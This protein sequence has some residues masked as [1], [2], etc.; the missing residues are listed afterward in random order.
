VPK[1]PETLTL[2]DGVVMLRD[3]RPDDAPALRPVCGDPDVCRF[4]SVPWIYERSAATDWIARVGQGRFAGT[5]LALA[6]AEADAELPVGNVNLVRFGA[7]GRDAALGYWLVP[8]GRGRGLATRAARLLCDWGFEQ[9][10]LARIELAILP[11]NPASQR[12]AERLG[13]RSSGLRRDSHRADG[14][15]WDMQIYELDRIDS[16]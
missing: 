2:R 10:G 6:I 9:L 14:R 1:L 3:W 15:A 11:D 8:S 4:T 16:P 13:A 7:N 12:V 5:T